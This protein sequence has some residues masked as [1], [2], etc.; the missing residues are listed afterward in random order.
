MLALS[1]DAGNGYRYNTAFKNQKVFYQGNYRLK[2]Q[3]EL[4]VSGGFIRNNFGANAFYAAP[5]DKESEET[6]ETA[7][8]SVVYKTR[9]NEVWTLKPR[10]SYRHNQDDYRYIKQQPDK[11]HNQHKTHTLSAE[12]NNTLETGIGTF[13]IG[14]EARQ[15]NLNSSNLGERERS[16][17]GFFSEYQFSE[18]EKLLVNVGAYSNYNSDY[19]WEFFPG[20]DAGYEVADNWKLF[21]NAGTGQRLPTYTDLYYKGPT[22]IGNDQLKPETSKYSEAG[23]KFNNRFLL[24][25]ASYFYRRIDNFIDWVR[26][27]LSQPWQPQNFQQI[28]TQGLTF[29]AGYR[30]FGNEREHRDFNLSANLA[31]T[32]LDP[33]FRKTNEQEQKISRYALESLRNQLTATLDLEFFKHVT[34]TFAGRHCERINYKAYTLLDSRVAFKTRYYSL[35]V[36]GTNLADVTY[37]EAGAVP[38]PGRWYNVGMRFSL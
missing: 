13:G 3:S 4:G 34:L 23:L 20:L 19:G 31:Y 12:L 10:L 9:M 8:A 1:Q 24:L 5:G 38:M 25:N 16:N 27:D 21:M 2:K 15:E 36:E 26:D 22:N 11:F 7:L 17:F 37:I 14:L 18:I 33:K 35:Y 32:H 30:P 29:S 28:N 6:V